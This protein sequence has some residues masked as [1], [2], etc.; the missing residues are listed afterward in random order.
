[1]HYGEI[2]IKGENRPYFE[3]MLVNNIKERIKPHITRIK[4][5]YGRLVVFIKPQ[6][7]Q[8]QIEIQGEFQQYLKKIPGIANFAFAISCP[9]D[10]QEI[11]T[12]LLKIAEKYPPKASFKIAARRSFKEFPYTSMELNEELGGV[13]LSKYKSKVD[14]SNPDRTYFVEITEHHAFLYV[15]KQNGLGG[16]PVGVSGR[17]LAFLSGGIDSPV[18]CYRMM[19]RGCS[20]ILLHFSNNRTG[21]KEKIHQLAKTLNSYQTPLKLYI[22]PFEKI[23]QQIIAFIPAKYRMITYRRFMFEIGNIIAKKEKIKAFTTGDSVSQVASQTLENLN[24]IWDMAS[25]PVLAPLIGL[26][27]EEIIREAIQIGTYDLSILPYSDCCSFLVDPHPETKA[28]L[29]TI[30]NLEAQLDLTD[31]ITK[32]INEAEV[33]NFPDSN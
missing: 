1:M 7:I 19:K 33:Y 18:A 30:E 10:I 3:R 29:V 21:L 25:L 11:N 24:V 14:L 4:R 31:Y 15:E 9:L 28:D 13:I 6:D 27:K 26:D 5:Y 22:I 8:N 23:Q 32:A 16:L 12:H 17:V 2:A 20:V